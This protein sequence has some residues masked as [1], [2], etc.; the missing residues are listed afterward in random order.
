VGADDVVYVGSKD[1]NF[2]AFQ[3]P[4]ILNGENENKK[5]DWVFQTGDII[6]SS[7]VIDAD[8]TIYFGS[9]DNSLYAINPGNLTPADSAW[10]MFHRDTAHSGAMDNIIIPEVISSIPE[11]NSIDVDIQTAP[12][13]VNF[14]P[15]V[16]A[17]QVDI[18]SFILEKKTESGTETVDGIA[19]LNFERYNNSGYHVVAVFNRLN[20]TDPLEYNTAYYGTIRYSGEAVT[21]ATGTYDK[22]YSWS[23]TTESAP[24][25]EGGSGD[26]GDPTCFIDTMLD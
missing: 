17:S 13:K 12:I 26:G 6:I 8:G 1:G 5:Q 21:D 14:S 25:K 9:R 18:D 15:E 7:P 23:F 10:S 20:K 4:A 22:T 2:Y 19:V 24:V 16:E 3:S 11:I